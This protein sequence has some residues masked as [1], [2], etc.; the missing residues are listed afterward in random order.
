MDPVLRPYDPER[1][2]E[3]AA[4][5]LREVGWMRA[6]E[7]VEQNMSD[8]TSYG[9]PWVAEVDGDAECFVQTV[10]SSTRYLA[11]TI[12]TC[13]VA[14]VSTSR[15][16]RKQGLASHLT[17]KAV[18]TGAAEDGAALAVLGMFEQGFYNQLGFGTGGYEHLYRFN[19][20]A[21]RVPVKARPPRRISTDDWEAIHAARASQMVTHGQVL[22][23]EPRRTYAETREHDKRSFVLGYADGPDGELT[24]LV[25]LL[26]DAGYHSPYDVSWCAYRTPE[27]FL[28]LM[29]MLKSFSDQ[30]LTVSMR[31]PSWLQLQDLLAQPFRRSSLTE[32]GKHESHVGARAFWQMRICDLPACLA[33]TNLDTA[34]GVRFNLDLSDPIERFLPENAPWRGTAGQYVVALGAE[35]SA[36]PGTEKRLPTLAASVNAFTRLWLG[37]VPATGLQATDDLDGP[38]EL[39][40]ALDRAI[41]LPTIRQCWPF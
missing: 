38:P 11:E 1:D 8:R 31:E 14:G 26:H 36:K 22:P 32:G 20:A 2:L 16:A 35:S 25:F 3:S 33:A 23:D 7:D 30:V 6:D 21:L 24:H 15:V 37:V 10:R 29:A 4:R 41:R 28:E 39:V 5:V 40:A 34:H 17:A 18:A 12:P 19:P 13:C 9:R 27:Q